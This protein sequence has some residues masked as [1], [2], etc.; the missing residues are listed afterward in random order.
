MSSSPSS[1][2]AD[3]F[4]SLFLHG[5]CLSLH[6]PAWLMSSSPSSLVADV[7]LSIFLCGWCLLLLTF[8]ADGWL[9]LHFPGWLI[10]NFVCNYVMYSCPSSSMIKIR[11]PRHL[12]PWLTGVFQSQYFT[13]ITVYRASKNDN[14]SSVF[15]MHLFS[16][17]LASTMVLIQGSG[18]KSF[19]DSIAYH[20]GRFALKSGFDR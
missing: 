8:W 17:V 3:V 2:V 19:C 4:L 1:S 13:L 10:D 7:F 12:L 14:T 15:E 20:S 18:T 5:W 9:P 11:L 16:T 6:L